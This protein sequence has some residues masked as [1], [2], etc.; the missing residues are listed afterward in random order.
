MA[1]NLGCTHI[2]GPWLRLHRAE[3]EALAAHLSA[4]QI[5]AVYRRL[6]L[7]SPALPTWIPATAGQHC[8]FAEPGVAGALYLADTIE[9][10]VAE[11]VH[12]HG[13]I[14]RE[15]VGTPPG[16]RAVFRHLLF[17][18]DGRMAEVVG[19][20]SA[21]MRADDYGPSW[22]FGRKVRAAG[23]DGIRYPSVRALP[24][25]CLAV[26]EERAVRFD[27]VEFGAI[28]LEWDGSHSN[29]MA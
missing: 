24:G 12:H 18:V 4:A 16:T 13:R 22:T 10:C 14:C 11:V 17:Q 2:L 29:R 15:S 1:R 9:T 20:R 6:R 27:R 21:A 8:R 3:S 23:L 28:V 26:L 25:T 7:P 19:R 5:D